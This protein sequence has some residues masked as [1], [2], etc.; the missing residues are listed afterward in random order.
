MQNEGPALVSQGE[1][2]FGESDPFA[3]STPEMMTGFNASP[4][5]VDNDLT[6][7]EVELMRVAEEAT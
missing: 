2:A 6:E 3:N 1:D 7:E 4:A 5:Q